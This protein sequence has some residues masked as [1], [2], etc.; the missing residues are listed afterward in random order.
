MSLYD[1]EAVIIMDN[2]DKAAVWLDP[3]DGDDI[4]V[5]R[6]VLEMEPGSKGDTVECTV[7]MW[8]AESKGM[9]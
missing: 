5:P 8:F 7:P 1:F 4:W 2:P 9:I 3:V 6:S